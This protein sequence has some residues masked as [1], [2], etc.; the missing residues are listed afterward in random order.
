M[1]AVRFFVTKIRKKIETQ[2]LAAKKLL[3]FNGKFNSP[4]QH[5][6]A[7]YGKKI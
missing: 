2:Y 5:L 7:G 4:M 3:F 1:L 6:S